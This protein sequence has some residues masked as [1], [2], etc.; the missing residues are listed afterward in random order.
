MITQTQFPFGNPV[1]DNPKSS[2]LGLTLLIA[3]LA[4]SSGTLLYL[5]ISNKQNE[6]R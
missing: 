6:N 5:H 2:F 1:S 4:I 3:A